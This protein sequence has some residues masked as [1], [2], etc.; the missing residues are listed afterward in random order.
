MEGSN[1]AFIVE[2]GH[3][4]SGEITPQGAKNEA[5]QVLCAV[6]LTQEKVTISNLPDIVDV[7][8]LIELIRGLGVETKKIDN[9]TYSFEAKNVDLEHLASKEYLSSVSICL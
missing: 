8:L 5:L 6:L 3:K 1:E 7:R 2:G 4:L 9:N